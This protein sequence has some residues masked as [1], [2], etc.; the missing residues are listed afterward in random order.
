MV[1]DFN[2]KELEDILNDNVSNDLIQKFGYDLKVQKDEIIA[3]KKLIKLSKNYNLVSTILDL[4]KLI[5][6]SKLKDGFKIYLTGEYEIS[7][8]EPIDSKKG[9]SEFFSENE[10]EYY[11]LTNTT[12]YDYE[13]PGLISSSNSCEFIYFDDKIFEYDDRI[14]FS[15]E[16]GISYVKNPT[17]EVIDS[18]LVLD[19]FFSVR[20]SKDD[21]ILSSEEYNF[22]KL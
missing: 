11:N 17:F 15:N 9:I 21:I 3:E 20:Y 8:P 22:K 7:L 13:I 2:L 19:S 1:D 12:F 5:T 4:N 14:A 18:K 10:E 6:E 16:F